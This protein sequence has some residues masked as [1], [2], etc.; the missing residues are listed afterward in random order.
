MKYIMTFMLS[1]AFA[2][3]AFAAPAPEMTAGKYDP[4]GTLIHVE[5]NG[6]ICDFCAVAIEKVFMKQDEVSGVAVNLSEHLIIVSLKE[7]ESMSNETLTK[8]ITDS[9]Y[10]VASIDRGPTN[11]G[12]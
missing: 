1:L 3:T 10:N 5:A 9:G 8:L 11:A 4:Q 7:G 12:E 2:A 6:L